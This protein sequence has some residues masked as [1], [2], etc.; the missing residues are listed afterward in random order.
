MGK[1]AETLDPVHELIAKRWSPR[2]FADKPV[3]PNKLRSLLEAARWAPSC[4]NEQPWHFIVA[5]KE[6]PE[7]FE[8]LLNCLVDVNIAWAKQAPVLMLSVARLQFERNDK[9]NHHA[10]HDVGMAVGNLTLQATALD[11]Y[12]HQMAGF[13]SDK[14]REAFKI[15]EKFEP[16]AAMALGYL[17]DP[18]RLPDDLRDRET[19]S[20]NRKKLATFVFGE[21]WGVTSS[22]FT[23]LA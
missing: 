3:E 17:G 16:V 22:L 15:P 11:L 10:F 12:L 8:R 5:T 1:I 9:P 19:A 7:E 23:A 21:T 18:Q 4:F 2:A 14:A 20:R 6:K 13:H